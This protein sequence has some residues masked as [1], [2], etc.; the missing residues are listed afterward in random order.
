MDAQICLQ[1]GER[2]V[3]RDDGTCP[4]CRGPISGTASPQQATEAAPSSFA[5]PAPA[6]PAPV[7]DNPYA[8][9][10]A[11]VS[12]YQDVAPGSLGEAERVR[13]YYLTHE[14]SVQSIGSLYYLSAVMLSVMLL[15][16]IFGKA[17]G[18]FDPQ[19]LVI[20]VG[21]IG[22][23]VVF[24]RGLRTLRPWVRIPVGIFAGIG[25]LGFP[26]GTLISAY[27]LY[28]LFSRK[29]AMVFSPGYQ[30]IIRQTPHIRYRTSKLAM[31]CLLLFLGLVVLAIVA[32]VLGPAMP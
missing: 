1:C 4:S 14:A 12:P 22:L 25:L 15:A 21:M 10:T 26:L 2:V 9:P 7:S 17:G 19:T 27:I 31:G 23:S 3:P 32:A 28:L 18:L 11:D 6:T 5:A 24:G 20:C 8:S 30:E 16:M 13:R 29:G